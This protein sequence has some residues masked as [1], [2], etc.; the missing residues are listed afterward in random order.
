MA[1]LRRFR[2]GCEVSLGKCFG[3]VDGAISP[4]TPLNYSSQAACQDAPDN[5]EPRLTKALATVSIQFSP[6]VSA[7]WPA[8]GVSADDWAGGVGS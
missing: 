2:L 1:I 7:A 4:K 3:G 8:L 6:A 5:L